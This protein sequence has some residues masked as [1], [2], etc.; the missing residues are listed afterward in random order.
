MH[1][2]GADY[3][4]SATVLERCNVS[5]G[6]SVISLAGPGGPPAIDSIVLKEGQG[7]F[8]ADAGADLWHGVMPVKPL[9]QELP[10][11]RSILGLDITHS[12]GAVR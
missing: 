5:G 10:A 8:Q 6:A 11:Y 4:V 12:L 3:I 1:Q 9:R 2:D 7:L